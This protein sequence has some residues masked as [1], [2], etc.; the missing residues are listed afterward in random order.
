[1]SASRDAHERAADPA[2]RLD[3]R[4]CL[5]TGG[6]RG[7]GFA[8]AQEFARAGARLVLTGRDRNAA[9]AAAASIRAAG[10][11]AAG[12]AYDAGSPDATQRL[13][14]EVGQMEGALDILVNNAAILKPHYIG[15]LTGTE[16]DELFQVNVKAPLFL[17][18]A[19]HGLLKQSGA[20]AV[21]N[22]TAAGGHVPMAGIGAY[23]ATKAAVLNFTRTLAKEWAADRIRVNALTPGSVAT[24][25]ILPKDAERRERFIAEMASSNLLKRLADPVEI[26][27]AARF[28][29][30]DA[31]SFIT[32][33]VLIVDG[34]LLA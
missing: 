2:F 5:V 24:D 8:I 4:I 21:L 13:A 18:Q 10:G 6:T 26:A 12:T 17:C 15:K 20:G 25:M 3:G 19:L 11:A 30:S 16:F 23:S 33:Q 1:M 7:I 27:R 14:D 29:V 32:G 34:G 22:I 28:L 31:A 9:E